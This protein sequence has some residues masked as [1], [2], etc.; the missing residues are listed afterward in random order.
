MTHKAHLQGSLLSYGGLTVVSMEFFLLKRVFFWDNQ[1][2][3][4]FLSKL[5]Q[6]FNEMTIVE[7]RTHNLAIAIL[8]GQIPVITNWTSHKRRRFLGHPV[9]LVE[10]S[11]FITMN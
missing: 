11:K 4:G 10:I 5:S 6:I 2:K 3:S 7:A 1:S 8:K 9:H